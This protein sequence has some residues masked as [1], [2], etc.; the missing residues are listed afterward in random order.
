MTT[1]DLDLVRFTNIPMLD[2]PTTVTLAVEILA[3][4]PKKPAPSVRKAARKV[5]E[6]LDAL[7]AGW[8]AQAPAPKSEQARRAA[9]QATDNAWSALQR[10]L[11]AYG[12]LPVDHYPDAARANELGTVL[13]PDGLRFL[14]LPWKTQWAEGDKRLTQID[15]G[16]LGADIDKL[17]GVHF[18]AEIRR[19]H[20]E[21][22]NALGI[23]TPLPEAAPTPAVGEPL[24]ELRRNLKRYALQLIA[25]ADEDSEESIHAVVLALAPID[26]ARPAREKAKATPDGSDDAGGASA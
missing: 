7:R 12:Q 26:A 2:V 15:E 22:G 3:R 14:T 23:S 9:D 19:T 25:T 13:F 16:K 10:R 11:A 8:H 6:S 18:L 24:V 1:S 5:R 4:V 21:Y 20:E 17:A